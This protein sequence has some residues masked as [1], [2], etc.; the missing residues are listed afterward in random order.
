M[1]YLCMLCQKKHLASPTQIKC[2]CGGALWLNDSSLG[3]TKR[4][5]ISHDFTLWRYCKA[6][7]INREDVQVSFDETI[8]PMPQL[9]WDNTPIFAKMDSLMPTGSFKARGAAIVI[10]YLKKQGIDCFAEDSSGNGGSAYAGYCAKGG[11][12]LNVFI[13]AG[14]AAG[15]VVQTKMYGANCI[16]IEGSRADVANAAIDSIHT[17]GSYYVGHNWHPLFIEGVKSIA[18]EI[19]EQNNYQAPDNI[20]APAGNGSLIAGAYLGFK[21][22]LQ[23]GEITKMPRLFGIQSAAVNPFVKQFNHDTSPVAPKNTIAEGIRIMRSSRITEIIQ[24]VRETHGQF[25]SVSESQI[26]DALFKMGQKGF[27]IEPTSATAFA[28]ISKLISAGVIKPDEKTV[29][30]ITG[31]GL[32]ATDNISS[33]MNEK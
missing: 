26:K 15:K 28:G 31:H 22:L 33:L 14:T 19:W 16:E 13:P 2:D 1:Q 12:K 11:L 4:D 8:T 25:I 5:I 10:N 9:E 27:F 17:H 18:Y 30:V 32:K 29:G 3:L 24:F 7:P 20:V 23:Q 6:Y 21:A